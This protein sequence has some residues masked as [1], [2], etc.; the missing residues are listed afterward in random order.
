MKVNWF[1]SD[2]VLDHTPQEKEGFFTMVSEELVLLLACIDTVFL[3]LILFL[4]V[5]VV[6]RY[7]IRL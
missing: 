7:I 5:Y 2:E 4:M 3:I 6:V 1:I